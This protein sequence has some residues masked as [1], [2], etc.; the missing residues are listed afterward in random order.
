MLYIEADV[1]VCSGDSR[2]REYAFSDRYRAGSRHAGARV[3][4]LDGE[5]H[6]RRQGRPSV[7]RGGVDLGDCQ[8]GPSIIS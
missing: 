2:S 6:A 4:V 7:F 3:R 5:G 8:R 1:V